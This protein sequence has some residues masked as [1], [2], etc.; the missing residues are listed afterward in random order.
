M[1]NFKLAQPQTIAHVT[2]LTLE[3]SDKFYLLAG[4]TDL[5]GEIKN[6]II[7]PEVIVDLK[8]IPGLSYIKKEKDGVQIGAMTSL[9]ELTENP[10]IKNDYPGLHEAA[11]S[12]ATP[13]LR[14]MGTVGGNLCQRPRCWYYRDPQIKCRKKGGTKCFAFKGR[15]KYHAILGG[16]MCYI[17]H[18]SDLAPALI[19]LGAEIFISSPKKDK[20]IPMAD[21]YTLPRVN[22]RKE[23]I[24]EQ[25]EVLR[26]IK[27]P[28][29]KKGEKSTYHKLKERGSWDFAIVSAAVKGNISGGVFKDIRI[30]LGGVAPVPWRL[31]KAENIIKGEK[32]TEKLVRQAAREALIEARPLEE[33]KYKNELVETVLYRAVLSLV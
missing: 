2:S 3:K 13:Q 19:A 27:I 7:E 16:G 12:V 21:F 9:A 28:L 26:E 22:V 31:E 5:L 4:G 20:T 8:S 33:N 14:N 1:K 29:S 25:N 11:N 17:V 10:L 6:E 18:P 23:N 24:L 15:N 30:V 32:A